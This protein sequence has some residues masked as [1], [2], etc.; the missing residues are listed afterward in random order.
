M[1]SLPNPPNPRQ[2]HLLAVLPEPEC[3]RLFPRLEWVPLPLGEALANEMLGTSVHRLAH[4]RAEA[5]TSA[6]SLAS[7]GLPFFTTS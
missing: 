5:A 6:K 2:N 3:E 7:S 4:L 1:P